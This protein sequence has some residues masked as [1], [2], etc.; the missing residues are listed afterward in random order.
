MSLKA[1]LRFIVLVTLLHNNLFAQ[2][3]WVPDSSFRAQIKII[4]PNCLTAQDSLITLSSDVNNVYYMDIS[5]SFISSLSGIEYFSNLATLDCSG[6]QITSLPYFANLITLNCSSNLLTNL[7]ALPGYLNELNCSNNQLIS[8][9]ALSDSLSILNCDGNLLSSLPALP[10]DLGMLNCSNN[11]LTSLPALPPL[12]TGLQCSDNLLTNLPTLPVALYYLDCSRNQLTSLPKIPSFACYLFCNNNPITCFPEMA[13]R[14]PGTLGWITIAMDSTL[15]S[16]IPNTGIFPLTAIQ[17]PLNLP[18][19]SPSTNTCFT[20]YTSGYVFLDLNGNGI[21]DSLENGLNYNLNYSGANTVF[22]DSLGFFNAVSDTGN[23]NFQM[24]APTYYSFTTPS[25]QLVHVVNGI[26]D[27]IYFGLQPV[28]NVRDLSVD[29]TT[30]GRLRVGFKAN[31]LLHYQNVGTDTIQ[32]VVVKFLKPDSLA[33]LSLIP[34]ANTISGDTLLW[35]FSYLSPLQQGSILIKDSVFA[36]ATIGDTAIAYSWI[37]PSLGDSTIQNNTS[38]FITT[39]SAAYDP[40]DKSVSPEVILPNT[41]GYLDYTIRFQN[42]GT[43][44]A[45]QVMLTDTLSARLDVSSIQMISASHSHDLWVENGV[46]K[47][48][49][50]NILLP[51]SNTNELQSHGFVKF[52]IKPLAGLTVGDSIPNTAN[53]YFDYN[54]PVITNTIVVNVL[55]PLQVQELKETEMQI[56]PNPVQ[57]SIRIVNQHAGALGKIELINASGKVLETKTISNSTYIWNLQHLPAGTYI[58]RGQGWGQKLVKE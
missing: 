40:N 19:C 35:N 44:T 6:N 43:D 8:L 55:N 49:F 52:R 57:E 25:S 36:S 48:N 1:T 28:L 39:I 41:T 45:F 5:N 50:I 20:T 37:E 3:F 17:S 54:A 11:L 16:C 13:P 26:I 38:N 27:T 47:W 4:C 58:L 30:I 22:T 32:N 33:N 14:F 42:T 53:I 34:N 56:F 31:Y 23:I 51:D 24:L 2:N 7:P 18:F 12:M 9:P 46:A 29:L 15:I 21:K 10:L